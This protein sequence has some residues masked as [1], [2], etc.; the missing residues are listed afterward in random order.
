MT[1]SST[2]GLKT[3]TKPMD[4]LFR[5]LF[6]RW[7]CSAKQKHFLQKQ[8]HFWSISE[9]IKYRSTL[10]TCP[11]LPTLYIFLYCVKRNYYK[12]FISNYPNIWVVKNFIQCRVYKIIVKYFFYSNHTLKYLFKFWFV[13]IL[14]SF[15]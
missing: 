13:I 4:H 3:H 15:I 8:E 7:P 10:P 1:V 2:W 12:D 6:R 11:T 14:F 5:E 9:S